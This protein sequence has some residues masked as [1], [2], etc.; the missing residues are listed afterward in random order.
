MARNLR[1]VKEL[2]VVATQALMRRNDL[3]YLFGTLKAEAQIA[4]LA[5]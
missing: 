3:T 4:M 1:S 2:I 5:R